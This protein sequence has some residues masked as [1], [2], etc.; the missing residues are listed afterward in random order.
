MLQIVPAGRTLRD[1]A[2]TL[3]YGKLSAAE[4]REQLS[5]MQQAV[6][7]GE[8]PL[9]DLLVALVDAQPVGAVLAVRRAGGMAFVWPPATIDGAGNTARELLRNVAGRLDAGGTQFA[10]CLLETDDALGKA[11]MDDGGF[12]YCTDIL[13]LSRAVA[14]EF[15]S[16]ALS[17]TDYD[18]TVHSLFVQVIERTF[19]GTLDC[20]ALSRL[21]NGETVLAA[22]RATGRFDPA[23]WQVFH[24][25]DAA[26]GLLLAVDHPDRGVREIAYLGVVPEARGRGIGRAMLCEAIEQA[27]RAGCD[28]VEVSV[29]A[30]NRYAL[31]IYRHLSF[32]V[33]RRM[34]V[35]LRLRPPTDVPS[36]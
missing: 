31:E 5:Q 29:D 10:Q 22:H 19:S 32:S 7:A 25:G 23:S 34:A 4:R 8:I 28:S 18:A 36:D 13:L 9:D 1:A 6:E 11:L 15:P 27:R 17:T 30:C 26:V 20:P 14:P 24:F 35:H 12:P 33:Q 3:L 2:L 21:R 16:L